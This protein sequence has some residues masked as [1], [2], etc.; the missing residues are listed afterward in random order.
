M[1]IPNLLSAEETELIISIAKPR[2][3]ASATINKDSGTRSSSTAWVQRSDGEQVNTLA[4][5]S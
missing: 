2:M 4:Q 3:A 1:K 5:H